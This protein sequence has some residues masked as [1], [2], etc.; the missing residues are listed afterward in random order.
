MGAGI[1]GAVAALALQ[2]R[3]IDV[4]I[5]EQAPALGEI[6]AGIFL[7]PNAINVLYALGLRDALERIQFDRK[8]FAT[9]NYRTGEVNFG[10]PLDAKFVAKYGASAL[11]FHRA[12]LH[13]ALITAFGRITLIQLF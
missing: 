10:T 5:Y 11:D 3:N 1:G 7:S 4:Q 13:K 8:V 9:R 12:D 6:G 2:R